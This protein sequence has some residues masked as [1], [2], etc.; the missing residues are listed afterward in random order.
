MNSHD[1]V[2]IVGAVRSPIGNLNGMLKDVSAAKLGSIVIRALIEQTGIAPTAIDEVIMG[3]VLQAGV[4][5]NAARQA[6]ILAGIP[7]HTTAYTVN[8]VCGSGLKSVQLA[9]Q[10]IRSG[11]RKMVVCGG[12][13]SMSQ[14]PHLLADAR[15]GY[16][17]GHQSVYDTIIKDGLWCAMNDIHMG[18]TAE[19]ICDKFSL[20]REQLDQ[21]AAESQRRA[22]I[23]DQTGRFRD[24][25]VPITLPGQR[26]APD[27][28]IDR[29]EYIRPETTF[30]A[31]SKLRP[32]FR[33]DGYVTA[34]NS[35]G[36]NDGA[37]ALLLTHRSYAENL[38]LPPLAVIR[39]HATTGIDPAYMGL[40]P[41]SAT[42]KALQRARLTVDELDLIELNE[43]FASQS[44]AV[45]HE[46]GLDPAKV[47]VNGGAIALGHP[48]GASGAR[49][50]VSLI[51]EMRRR[52]VRYG[53]ATLCIGGGQGIATIIESV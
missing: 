15:K 1:D 35:S 10:A 21:F 52:Q 38:G 49:V 32:V 29:D 23:A 19:Y 34:G 5:Q 46:L 22:T 40:G 18:V 42:H 53:L 25:I 2:V 48:I 47:N 30:D 17:L 45:I 13:E 9:D 24:E 11:D 26:H 31:L 4:G 51:H 28:I 50:L 7:E 33:K 16:R 43:A 41:I 12:M 27:Q 8:Q 39:A 3:Q 37:A 6:A 44:L 36:I 20:T 14:A